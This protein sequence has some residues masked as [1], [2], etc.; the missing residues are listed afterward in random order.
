MKAQ[1]DFTEKE[2]EVF[3]QYVKDYHLE[4]QLTALYNRLMGLSALTQQPTLLEELMLRRK[5]KRWHFKE[6]V[7]KVSVSPAMREPRE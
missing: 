6:F 2:M 5:P 1:S 4:R 3:F 7:I